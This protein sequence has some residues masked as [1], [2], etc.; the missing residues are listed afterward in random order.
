MIVPIIIEGVIVFYIQA[1]I[2]NRINKENQK[3]QIQETIIIDFL[4][5]LSDIKYHEVKLFDGGKTYTEMTDVEDIINLVYELSITY[6]ANIKDLAKFEK[7]FIEFSNS[8]YE[9]AATWNS[10]ANK[11][12]TDNMRNS[13]Y[14]EAENCVRKTD[15]LIETIRKKL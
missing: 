14:K 3:R 4:K 10:C 1:L 2:T 12:L 6:K 13:I 8:W 11:Q 7:E 15:T 9:F 5:K